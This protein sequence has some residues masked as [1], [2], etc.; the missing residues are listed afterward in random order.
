MTSYDF[1]GDDIPI[2]TGSA[3][4]ALEDR[5]PE[6]GE[7]AVRKLMA[8]VDE[9]IPT[10][11]RP[12]DQPF[13]MPVED[14]FSISGRGTVATGR[15]ERGVVKVGEEVEIVGIRPNKKTICT[16]VEMFRKLLDQ[17]QAGDNVG[18][19]LRGIDR[20]GI[21]R[22]QVICKPGSVKPHTKFEAEA[23]ILTK[24]EGGRHTPF[25]A[26]YRPQFYFRT[27]DVTGT[28]A[29]PAGTEMVMPG[30]NLKFEVD[31]DLA[32]RHGGEA[33][34]RHPR[35]RPHRRRRRRLE[36]H[37]VRAALRATRR[38]A[39]RSARAPR[40]FRRSAADDRPDRGPAHLRDR[41]HPRPARP[42][43]RD[44]RAHPRRPRGAAAP[45]TRWS[46]SSATT[47]TA[48]RR[49]RGV[50]E[51]LIALEAD[52]PAD[53]RSCSATTTATSAPTSTTRTGTTAPTTGCTT[54]WAATPPSPPTA[55]PAPARRGPRRPATPS[56]RPSRREHMAFLDACELLIRDRRLPLRPRRHPARACRSTAQD[57]DDLIWIREPF[58]SSTADFGF[59]VVHGHTIVP[60]VEHH[61]NRIAIDTGAVRTGV[62]SCLVLE[63]DAVA[64]L[65]PGGPRPCPVGSGLAGWRILWLRADRRDHG[66]SDPIGSGGMPSARSPCIGAIATYL[67]R[68]CRPLGV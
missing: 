25:F 14:V 34:L 24:E 42:A 13:L 3:L 21:E 37:R 22:G 31:A 44:A 7:Q 6:I 56:P 29:L 62:L 8:A 53:A 47:S 54:T 59:K 52:P 49:V 20:D 57:R 61:P 66:P 41:R 58:L 55:C 43:D 26:N 23:Y 50:I 18:L 46:S 16:G 51:A 38:G 68:A 33:A 9:Y 39:G 27:T 36:D 11:E 60:A 12:V 64:L 10:P 65:E 17:G 40:R 28:V 5:D 63:G 48:A 1:P 45:A 19:L 32:D 2:I 35:G 15:I 67:G 4:A 30:D